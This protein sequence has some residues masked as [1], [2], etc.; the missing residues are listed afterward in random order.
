MLF[1]PE[2]LKLY[3]FRLLCQVLTVSL[4]LRFHNN[5][6]Q[7]NAFVS[8]GHPVSPA[9]VYGRRLPSVL[10]CQKLEPPCHPKAGHDVCD[11]LTAGTDLRK[12][13]LILAVRL[14]QV[15]PELFI[16]APPAYIAAEF[17]AD[18]IFRNH[19]TCLFP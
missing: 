1:E 7:D 15:C 3:I 14:L 17:H 13:D 8:E 19:W 4:R 2:H 5:I 9:Y 18:R 16:D 10:F 6:K 11:I 12:G